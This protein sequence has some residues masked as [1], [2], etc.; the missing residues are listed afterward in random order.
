MEGRG[1]GVKV[2][3]A[4]GEGVAEAGGRFVFSLALSWAGWSVSVFACLARW[5]GHHLA[6]LDGRAGKGLPVRWVGAGMI[7]SRTLLSA[8]QSRAVGGGT[9]HGAA[10]R[11][12]GR[13][14]AMAVGVGC[15]VVRAVAVVLLC[16]C[17][18]GED[19]RRRRSQSDAI[20]LGPHLAAQK[21]AVASRWSWV[22]GTKPLIDS[23][24][25]SS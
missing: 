20:D 19:L 3:G 2:R 16:V 11:E 21:C 25:A 14:V 4:G 18:C 1:T 8:A 7:F 22:L 24:A 12:R 9:G 5:L 13:T 6:G 10:G 15:W 23:S 17:G